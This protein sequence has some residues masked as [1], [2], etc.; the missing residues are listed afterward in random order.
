[1]TEWVSDRT[2]GK[3]GNFASLEGVT[4]WATAIEKA[5]LEILMNPDFGKDPNQWLKF[6]TT[7]NRNSAPYVR[8]RYP[9]FEFA[10]RK[11]A[12]GEGFD[13]FMRPKGDS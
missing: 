4:D 1:M 6:T 13:W 8:S 2:L 11:A 12:T 7:A 9:R 5:E 10:T 3:K